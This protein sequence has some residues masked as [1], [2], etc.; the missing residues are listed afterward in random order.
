MATR[1]DDPLLHLLKGFEEFRLSS[2]RSNP[3]LFR[4]LAQ[5]GQSPKVLVIGC[6]DS[7]VDPAILTHCQPGDL[8]V[9]RNVA[10]IVPPYERDGRHH[11]TS[12]ALEFGVR[13]LE[14]EHVIVLGHAA[15]GGVRALAQGP[16]AG[17]DTEFE[18]LADWVGIAAEARTAVETVLHA[19]P[20]DRRRRVLEQATV[21]LSLRNLLDYP[22]VRE[23]VES[24]RLTLHGWYFD[25]EDGELMAFDAEAL[26]FLAV[27]GRLEGMPLGLRP[28][29]RGCRCGTGL[30]LD[31]FTRAEAQ[32]EE[33]GRLA[34][35]RAYNLPATNTPGHS[36]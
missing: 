34:V 12:S 2:L 32:R 21:L 27:R 31:A 8:F 20:D 14:V 7:R 10:A 6:S 33:P 11:G 5:E 16:D 19:A 4:R 3:G 36:S 9:V 35:P 24:G 1:D 28:C 30:D 18:F 25:I 15:C 22:W 13:S 29:V 26:R 17:A 23:R